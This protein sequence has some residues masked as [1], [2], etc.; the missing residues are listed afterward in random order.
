MLWYIIYVTGVSYSAPALVLVK[1]WYTEI[2]VLLF[3]ENS[4][5]L[6]YNSNLMEVSGNYNENLISKTRAN[7]IESNFIS[8]LTYNN[9]RLERHYTLSVL[10]I[11]LN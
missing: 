4:T 3:R 7:K 5:L 8:V 9:T 6:F 11:I 1:L 2:T 10:V